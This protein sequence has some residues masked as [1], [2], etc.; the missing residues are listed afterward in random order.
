MGPMRQGE[1]PIDWR[2]FDHFHVLEC[3]ANVAKYPAVG[4]QVEIKIHVI[5]LEV[6]ASYLRTGRRALIVS[7]LEIVLHIL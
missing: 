6:D 3:T 5:V 4:R 1:Q 7:G 2:R